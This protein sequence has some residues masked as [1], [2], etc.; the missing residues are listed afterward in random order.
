MFN[1]KIFPDRRQIQDFAKKSVAIMLAYGS[2][3]ATANFISYLF[4]ED[5]P[6]SNRL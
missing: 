4:A 3:N 6:E 5:I 2:G 1:Q